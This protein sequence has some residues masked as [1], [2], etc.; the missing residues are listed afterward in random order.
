M[1]V[2]SVG[3]LT[4]GGTGKTP[5]VELIAGDLSRLG[6]KPAI[7]S[8]GYGAVSGGNEKE[9]SGNDE[10]RVLAANLPS[11]KHYQGADRVACGREALAGGSDILVLDDGFQHC[12]LH[13]DLDVVLLDALR[14][15]DN[16]RL[17]PA[18]LLREP[19]ETL[20]RA[21]LL[22]VTRVNLVSRQRRN[23]IGGFLKARFPDVPVLFFESRAVC[24][25]Q[26]YGETMEAGSLADAKVFAFCG[27]GNPHSFRLALEE[28]GVHTA[29][30]HAFR[31]HQIYDSAVVD[32][33]ASWAGDLGVDTVVMT[34]K[35]AVKL[36]RDWLEKHPG[37]RWLFLR[38]EQSIVSGAE[39]YRE[40]L[41]G[42]AS[43]GG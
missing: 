31:D 7:L 35:D 22:G 4:C 33:I 26:L 9:T 29:G 21:D 38:I 15:F 28:L 36:E 1:P 5:M 41:E 20:A 39:T 11:I 13:R 32:R 3:N 42:L 23:A 30:F 8:R 10:Y 14:P 17:L 43:A 37:V 2:V 25:R 12:R 34:Q 18:G 27:I 40:A 6:W 24:W 16:G 19:V